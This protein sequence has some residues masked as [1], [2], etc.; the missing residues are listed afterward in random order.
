MV[1][2]G[3]GGVNKQKRTVTD[4][5]DKRSN[6]TCR[7]GGKTKTN[8]AKAKGGGVTFFP[9]P[10]SNFARQKAIRKKEIVV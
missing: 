1:S 8:R 3:E 5:V 9:S 10:S 6:P 2:S 4:I 7:V